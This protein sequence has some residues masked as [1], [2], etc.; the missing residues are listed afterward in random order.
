MT[1]SDFVLAIL[2][3]VAFLL[4]VSFMAY[5]VLIVLPYLKHKAAKP[6][7]AGQFVWHFI[8]PC[9]DEEAVVEQTVRRLHDTFPSASIWCVD[10]ASVD[11]TPRILARLAREIRQVQVVTRRFPDAQVGKGPALNAAW[12]ALVRSLPAGTDPERVVVGVVDADARLDP[13]C[14]SVIA[15]REFFGS[16][17]VGAVQIQVRVS[18]LFDEQH[19]P[20]ERRVPKSLLVRLQDMEFCGPIAAMQLLRRRTGSV[21]MG[22][23][24]QFTRLS[25]LNDIAGK[26]GTPWHG[27]LLEDLELGL[28]VLLQGSRTEYCHDTFVVQEGL[29]SIKLL[30]RQRSRWAQ[31]S[32]QCFQYLW[33]ILRSP[34]IGTQ[35]ALEITYF[36]LLPWFQLLGGVIYLATTLV[37]AYYGLTTPGGPIAWVQGGAWGLV[38]LFVFFGLSPF[39]LWGPVYRSRTGHQLSRRGAWVVGVAN[40]AYTYLHQIAVWWALARVMQARN[41]WKKTARMTKR[42]VPSTATAVA[43][44]PARMRPA[45]PAVATRRGL[46]AVGSFTPRRPTPKGAT[47]AGRLRIRPTLENT[48]QDLRE[49]A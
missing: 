13:R 44:A 31:G 24:G 25:V 2:N 35:G 41:D 42:R 9:L 33:P 34:N 7:D 18:D 45:L 11:D 10:D 14:L 3:T 19:D 43:G 20:T 4:C 48:E 27:A 30:V 36:L 26:H 17:K 8:V 37:A 32:M 1:N 16:L 12:H 38:P 40:W 49:V 22:G 5:V 47:V 15:G 28:H 39:L 21:G 6:G 29:P 46:T 23:N